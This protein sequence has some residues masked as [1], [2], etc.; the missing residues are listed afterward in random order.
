[1]NDIEKTTF[2]V[3]GATGFLGRHVI[4]ILLEKGASVIAVVRNKSNWD[5]LQW[6]HGVGD[7]SVVESPLDDVE[8]MGR[9]T[10]NVLQEGHAVKGLFHLAAY[11][12]HGRHNSAE[13]F[14]TNCQGTKS[15]ILLAKFLSCKM[16]FVSTSGTVASFEHPD[17]WADEH[18]DIGLEP[19]KRWPYYHSKALAEIESR[20]LASEIGVTLI[21]IRP[22][23]MLGPGD[24][25]FRSTKHILKMLLGK[26]PFLIDGGINFVDIR[27]AAAAMVAAL[28][29]TYPKEVY[30]LNGTECGIREFFDMVAAVSG[31]KA[32]TVVLPYGLA[33]GI[34][35]GVDIL[36]QNL[37]LSIQGIPEPVVVEM[38]SRHWGLKSRYSKS[39][40][41]Y[42]SREPLQT[43]ADTV[44]WLRKNHPVLKLDRAR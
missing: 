38:A 41:G 31:A 35:S 37:G 26:L 32:P 9:E 11:V 10:L 3:T 40:L 20:A 24:H 30:H 39:E 25:R 7:I 4:S 34:A 36:R 15:M 33:H 19:V 14:E 43:L 44:T 17:D 18:S 16:L 22:P 12:D 21:I 29:L 13:V 42:I 1:M 23:A 5:A 6:T 28:E 2:L 27:D 8:L